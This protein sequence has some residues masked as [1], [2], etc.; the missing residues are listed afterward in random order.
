ME[1]R[2]L[3]LPYLLSMFIFSNEALASER[4]GL[5]AASACV[6]DTCVP[7]QK[8]VI[9]Q[10]LSLRAHTP[11][12]YWGFKVYTAALYAPEEITNIEN[13]LGSAPMRLE[14][15]YYRK[16]S[17]KDF[18]ES[19]E[20]VLGRNPEVNLSDFRAELDKINGLYRPVTEGDSYALTFAPGRGLT[21][22]L[23]DAPLGTVQ[24]DKFARAYLGI[25]LS[26]YSLS[27]DLTR[28]LTQGQR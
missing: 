23:N 6:W 24:G 1:R 10:E 20:E 16:F 12:R 3:L 5:L 9:G 13:A 8:T 28:A 11:F 4:P 27:K 15:H 26:R 2:L 19:G 14:I 21:L 17:A 22:L 18:R 7:G 25:W